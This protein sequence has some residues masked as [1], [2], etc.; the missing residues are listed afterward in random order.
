MGK[1]GLYLLLLTV[2]LACEPYDL[3]KKNFPTCAK[4]YADIGYTVGK[5]DVTFFLANPQGDIGVAGWDP[6]DGKGVSRVGSR[7]TY[8]YDKPGTYTI[9]LAL[10][11][12]CDDKFTTTRPITVSN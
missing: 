11:N 5:L 1:H 7:V 9:T 3:T 6:G 12:A 4:P 2:T 10:A 8:T